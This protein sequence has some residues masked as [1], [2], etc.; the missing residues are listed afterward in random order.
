M[1]RKCFFV[2][3]LVLGLLWLQSNQIILVKYVENE[4][5]SA[6]PITISKEKSKSYS[7]VQYNPQ[8]SLDVDD[9]MVCGKKILSFYT[10]STKSNSE[11]VSDVF[12]TASEVGITKKN[13][14]C[15]GT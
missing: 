8:D 1:N 10:K 15:T 12:I 11:K 2:L 6:K 9:Q 7:Y 14:I 4:D 5:S 3:V 13:C